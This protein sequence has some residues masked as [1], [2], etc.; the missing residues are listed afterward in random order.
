MLEQELKN[1]WKN[2]S[3]ASEIT[4]ET[5]QLV[6]ELNTRVSKIQKTIRKRDVR[7][8][9]ASVIGIMIFSFLMYE[10]P[11]PI[12]KLACGISILW[13]VF[14]IFKFRKSKLQNTQEELSLS[15]TEEL[16]LQEKTLEQQV[17]LLDSA[18]FWYAGPSF[19]ANVVFI[20]GLKNPSDYN[21]I[22][23]LSQEF[24]PL[25]TNAKIITIIGLAIFNLFVIWMNKKAVKNGIQ[26]I[27]E[28][29]KTVQ[30]QLKNT[31]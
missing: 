10:I 25:T 27:L 3:Q 28:N 1:I 12:T 19:L 17:K 29:I 5:N 6:N 15:L 7:E 11:F 16:N 24:L 18:A 23:W 8:I 22:N 30:Q 9:S 31:Y 14:V 4:I 20:I 21:W 13:F 2:S 26:P